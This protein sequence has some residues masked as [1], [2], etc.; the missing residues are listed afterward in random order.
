MQFVLS[1]LLILGISSAFGQKDQLESNKAAVD[2]LF[3]SNAEK[4]LKISEASIPIA[5]SLNDTLMI[6][7]FL[8][9][10]G[11]LNRKLGNYDLAIEQLESCLTYKQNWKDLRDLSITNNNI[12]RAW[13]NKGQYDKGASYFIVCLELMEKANNKQG[14]AYFSNNLG[15]V[16]DLSHNYAKALKYYNISLNA[17]KALKDSAG[18]MSTY[19]NLGIVYFNLDDIGQ[20]IKYHKLSLG[21][22]RALDKKENVAKSLSSLGFISIKSG[23]LTT[24]SRYLRRAIDIYEA[25]NNLEGLCL[26]QNN[27][28]LYFQAKMNI[29]SAVFYNN[30]SINNA[31]EIK[32]LKTLRDAYLLKSELL[33]SQ[34]ELSSSLSSVRLAMGYKDSLLDEENINSITEMEARYEYEKNQRLLMEQEADIAQR[35]EAIAKNESEIKSKNLRLA[36]SI[37]ASIVLLCV[38]ILFFILYKS[39]KKRSQLLDAQ[40]ILIAKQNGKL[41]ELNARLNSE[42]DNTKMTLSE[43]EELLHAVYAQKQDDLPEELVNLS[44]R[45][46]E[47]LAHLALG[48]SDQEIADKLFISK[49]TVKTHLRRIYTKLLVRG[50]AEAVTIAHKYGIIG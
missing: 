4:G 15:V 32:S 6:T 34:G 30:Q 36:Y 43:K 38:V 12:G 24:A 37:G 28:A 22:A 5:K 2:S 19:N 45:E 47:V 33:E 49:A 35:N 3:F 41:E 10:A 17:K 42:L 29:D 1:I 27:M 7:Y 21:L 25:N 11:E 26:A 48:W 44:F 46:K 13:I 23:A 8:D 9:Q 31:L 14:E 50:R 16:F 40:N 39:S 18:M 20:S